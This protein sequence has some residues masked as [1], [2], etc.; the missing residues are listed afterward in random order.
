MSKTKIP[1]AAE[2]DAWHWQARALK[3]E[4]ESAEWKARFDL[5]LREI[6]TRRERRLGSWL[7]K[8]CSGG[9]G[10]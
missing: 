2:L 9:R 1:S 3:A 8:R 5:L 7:L 10:L 4:A 6:P